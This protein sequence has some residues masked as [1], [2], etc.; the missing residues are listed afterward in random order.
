MCPDVSWCPDSL[1]C[2]VEASLG[3]GLL[4]LCLAAPHAGCSRH[5]GPEHHGGQS[6]SATHLRP[7]SLSHL[8]S[9]TVTERPL[10]FLCP[11]SLFYRYFQCPE[12]KVQICSQGSVWVGVSQGG[13]RPLPS[14][15]LDPRCR[16][17]MEVVLTCPVVVTLWL[18]LPQNPRSEAGGGAVFS[19][20]PPPA[21]QKFWIQRVGPAAAAEPGGPRESFSPSV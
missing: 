1:L 13:V 3:P 20:P 5:R 2:S 15:P 4:L 10:H 6:R 11:L 18:L 19:S 21:E 16:D 8:S 17:A 9:A 14:P 12:G 7:R